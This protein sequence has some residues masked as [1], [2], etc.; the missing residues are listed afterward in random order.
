MAEESPTGRAQRYADLLAH[1]EERLELRL[2]QPVRLDV[3]FYKYVAH[4]RADLCAGK[5][6][7]IRCGALPF[8]RSKRE[9]PGLQPIAVPI[10]EP[11]LAVLFTRAGSDIQSLDGLKGR[12]VAFGD[13]NS[14]VSFRAQMTLAQR[15]L[16]A[17]QL[18]G[19]DFLDSSLE[20]SEEVRDIGLVEA[21][22]RIGY[23]HSH[24]QVI[25]GVLSGRYDAGV[26]AFRAFQINH[27]RGLA[28]IPDSE[29]VSS[30]SVWVARAGL[31]RSVVNGLRDALTNLRSEPWM[32]LLP[33]HPQGYETL[34]SETFA[35]EEAWLDRI[36]LSFPVK[37]SPR[38]PSP[39]SAVRK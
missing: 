9:V 5:V 34:T 37:P 18:A 14:T 8:V 20:F 15:G 2:S 32:A 26:A 29:F 38:M 1:L 33:D 13:T 28:A 17:T 24:A 16:A 21:I 30:R 25:E 39:T 31:D 19:Y 27:S 4:C 35:I 11:K 3:R 7:F 12:R 23:L 36:L 6:D 10:C 22:R